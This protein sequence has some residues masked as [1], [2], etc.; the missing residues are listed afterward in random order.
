MHAQTHPVPPASQLEGTPP[1]LSAQ[2]CLPGTHTCPV[3]AHAQTGSAGEL[4]PLEA[5]FKGWEGLGNK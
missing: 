5:G 2:A 3:L 1:C 4:T